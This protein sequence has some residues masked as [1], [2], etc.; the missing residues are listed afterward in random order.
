MALHRR[1]SEMLESR[2]SDQALESGALTALARC[3]GE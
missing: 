1:S 3:T 2:A